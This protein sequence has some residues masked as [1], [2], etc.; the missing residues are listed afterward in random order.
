[1]MCHRSKNASHF[2]LIIIKFSAKNQNAETNKTQTQVSNKDYSDRVE[3]FMLETTY[4][5]H[6]KTKVNFYWLH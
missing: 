1:M 6:E 3:I 4:L 2:H 5:I